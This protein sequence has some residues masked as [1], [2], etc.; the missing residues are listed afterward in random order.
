M[1]RTVR[2]LA[3]AAIGC[4]VLAAVSWFGARW[5]EHRYP[6]T[7][8]FIEVDGQRLH[9]LRDG[10]GPPL[11]LLHGASS[12]LRDMQASLMPALRDDFTVVAFD[13]PGYGH[14]PRGDGPWPSP[15]VQ[16]GL[17]LDALQAMGLQ[18]PL[19]LGHSWS[20]S[21]VMAALLDHPQRVA[22]GVLLAGAAGHWAGSVGWSYDIARVPLLG[23]LFAWLFV[24]PAGQFL[25][26]P[27]VAAVLA[28]NPVP[29]AYV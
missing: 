19:V 7:G 16:A 18:Q 10:R 23:E 21:I 9:Y 28:P 26:A 6:P 13:R 29:E 8:E 24:W 15:A 12:N 17:F 4:A 5:T 27:S 3:G 20:G 25:L 2:A 1:T 14:S 22:G 11:L